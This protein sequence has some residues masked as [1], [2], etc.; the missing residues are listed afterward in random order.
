MTDGDERTPTG[1]HGEIL[2]YRRSEREEWERFF[3]QEESDAR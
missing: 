2:E 3:A 1:V